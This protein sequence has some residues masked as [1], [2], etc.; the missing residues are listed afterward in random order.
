MA[1]RGAKPSSADRLTQLLSEIR[2]C[3][4]CIDNPKGAALPHEPRPVLQARRSAKL[5]IFGQAPG[6]KVHK[7]GKPFM[8]PSGVRLRAWMGVCEGEFYDPAQL[9]IVPMGF[10]FPGYDKKGGD[11]PPRPEC[12][13]V[14]RARVLEELPNLELVLLIGQY[15]QAWHLGRDKKRSL[16]QTVAAW[17]EFLTRETRPRFLPLPH[18]S[19]RNN[20]WISKNP[21][22]ETELLPELKSLVRSTL[23]R[24]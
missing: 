22:F 11:L 17:R 3:R 10:C 19:W 7:T 1:A 21:W 15:A 13:E 6:L 23:K 18:P 14:W 24:P 8:D 16:T 2:A 12:A 4:V 5:A 9:A 20:A